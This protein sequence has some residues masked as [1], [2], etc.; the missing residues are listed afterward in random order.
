ME[1]ILKRLGAFYAPHWIQIK[2]FELLG[3]NDIITLEKVI[4]EIPAEE[5]GESFFDNHYFH[6]Q[7]VNNLN[8]HSPEYFYCDKENISKIIELEKKAYFSNDKSIKNQ[9]NA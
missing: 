2:Y 6:Y 9:F 8:P 4:V 7:I 1:I 5:K 3:F